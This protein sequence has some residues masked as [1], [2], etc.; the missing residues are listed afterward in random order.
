MSTRDQRRRVIESHRG[1]FGRE[2]E[3]VVRAPG[4]VA[5]L[6][7]HVDYSDGWVMP[8]AIERAIYLAAS[9]AGGPVT[10]LAALDEADERRLDAASPP[11]PPAERNDPVHWSDLPAGLAWAFQRAGHAV[12]ALDVT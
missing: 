10:T 4:R 5:L 6:G 7:A 1:R 11:A 2:P 9:P 12:P 8:A 3:L